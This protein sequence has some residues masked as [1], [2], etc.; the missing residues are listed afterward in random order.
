MRGGRARPAWESFMGLPPRSSAKWGAG[1][2]LDRLCCAP[3][4]RGLAGA[5]GR[6]RAPL[7]GRSQPAGG[8]G[9]SLPHPPGGL[10]PGG[11]A[12]ARRAEA[13]ASRARG[14]GRGGPGITWAEAGPGAPGGLSPESGRRQRE[15]WRLLAFP[16]SRAW[17]PSRT[18]E[19]QPGERAHLRLSARPALPGAGL[20]S[21]PLSARNPGLVR[22][23]A[24]WSLASAGAP[25]RA[26]LSPAGALLLQPPARRVLCPRSEGGSRTGRAGPSGW[27]PPR[28]ARSA[29]STDRLKG[30]A[31][32]VDVA[33]PAPW[34]FRIT[35]GR[36][37]HTPIM[38]TKVAERGKAK[39]ADLRP[40]DIIVAINGESAEGMLHAEAQSK[41][42]QSPSPLRLQLDRSQATSPGQT[43]GDSS[44]EVLA[45]RFQGSV[46]T[47]T[48]S[49][50]SL[51]S[52]YSSPT[53]LSPRAGSPF[54]PPPSSSPLT[55]E[56]AISRSMDSE[57]GSLLLDEDSE[58]FKMLQENRE[59]RA[60]PRQSSS[61][62]LLQEALEAEERGGTPAF[63]PSSLS[64]QSSL[65]TSRAL[66][67][68]P[69]L[70][71][72]E[73]CSTSIANQAVRIQEGR[74]RHPG[75]YT[76]ADCGLNLKMR[77]HFWVG[78]E[79]Y[80]EKHARQRYSAPATL[81]SRA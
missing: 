57:G 70:H 80:C 11:S 17:A 78:D 55:G 26:A 27:A 30:M 2:S 72:C 69:K 19:R 68:P 28:G 52:S 15:R 64:P 42:R 5:P 62:R 6:M 47:Y 23:P 9:D 50:S 16:P 41:I 76:C 77:G 8:P 18:G 12:W 22:G 3:G 63:L 73:K 20:L 60:A 43:N 21:A 48:E 14:G 51:R 46:R 38:V 49:Q 13:A 79:L 74:Y 61:F 4:S 10:G 7:A 36:D 71:T 29:E 39:D 59:G 1:Q 45:T 53:S 24:P 81:S 32:T 31:L 67:T 37:F 58:V 44:L 66:A 25:P 56:A 65:P 34:G 33:G 75:C 35:G 40:G 54:S